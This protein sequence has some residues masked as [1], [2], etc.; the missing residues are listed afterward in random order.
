M[1]KEI[2]NTPVKTSD[3]EI[4]QKI[5]KTTTDLKKEKEGEKIIFTSRLQELTD[6]VK[7][8]EERTLTVD[9]TKE[10]KE[11]KTDIESLLKFIV[12]TMPSE[13]LEEMV[14]SCKKN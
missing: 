9:K 2:R 11:L 8:I 1:L 7:K 5:L 3:S 14:E 10:I 4:L 6:K 13:K 12:K